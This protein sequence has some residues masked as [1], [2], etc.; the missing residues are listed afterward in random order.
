MDK[1]GLFDEF[2]FC[3]FLSPFLLKFV[4][5][6]ECFFFENKKKKIGGPSVYFSLPAMPKA[7]DKKWFMLIESIVHFLTFS[8]LLYKASRHLWGF[9][10]TYFT[11]SNRTYIKFHD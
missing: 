8:H 1:K 4:N 11:Y 9:E 2:F 7:V 5:H 10:I 3:T 6:L